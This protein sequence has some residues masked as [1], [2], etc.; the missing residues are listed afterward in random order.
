V[1]FSR[2]F[3]LVT[4]CL[5]SSFGVGRSVAQTDVAQDSLNRPPVAAPTSKIQVGAIP[6]V[7]SASQELDNFA[8]GLVQGLMADGRA[9]GVGVLMVEKDH[10]MLQRNLAM[11]GPDTRFAAGGLLDLF[12]TIAAMQS[13]ERGRLATTTDIGT[14]LGE[15]GPRGITVEQI[16]TRQAGDPALLERVIEKISGMKVEDYIA[17]EIAGPLGMKATVLRDGQLE[18]TISDLS[19]LVVALA[20]DGAFENGRILQPETV[21]L[22]ERTHVTPHPALPGWAYGFAELRRNGWHALQRDGRSGE[23]ALRLVVVPD[24]KLGYV[25]V[26]RGRTEAPFWRALDNGLLD[27]SLPPRAA[28]EAGASIATPPP[29]LAAARAVAGDYEPVQGERFSLAVLK[30]GDHRLSV[31][32]GNDGALVLSGAEN[33]RLT[34]RPGGYWGTAD[35]NLNAVSVDGRLLLSTGAYRPLALYKRP[36]LYALL[37]LL[38]ALGAPAAF[39]YERRRKFVRVF[40]SDSVLAAAGASIGLLLLSVFVW[41]FAPAA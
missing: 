5:V 7:L 26:A 3:L 34:T 35:G 14:A 30:R 9:N 41:L 6:V 29:D 1:F 15:A 39:Y 27:K 31:R 17:K 11:V 24:A 19:H 33:A 4:M 21:V 37:A 38:A 10:V 32:A 28:T 8:A 18:T 2:V 13:I 23:F 40:P 12:D 36:E 20:N 25:L 22:L 16:L